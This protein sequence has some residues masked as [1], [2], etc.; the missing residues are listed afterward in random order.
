MDAC[1]EKGFFYVMVV[2]ERASELVVG[3]ESDKSW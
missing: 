2:I 1:L 3:Y